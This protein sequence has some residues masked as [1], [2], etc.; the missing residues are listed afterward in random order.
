MV[1]VTVLGAS[2]RVGPLILVLVWLLSSG[3]FLQPVDPVYSGAPDEVS[4]LL[5]RAYD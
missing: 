1:G 4:I 5:V 2:D 3:L